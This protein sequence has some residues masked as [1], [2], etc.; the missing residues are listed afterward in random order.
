M[1]LTATVM[2]WL[3]VVG[4]LTLQ[5]CFAK[6]PYK[7]DYTLQKRPLILRSLL[8]IATPYCNCYTCTMPGATVTMPRATRQDIDR[9]AAADWEVSQTIDD[10]PPASFDILA[11]DLRGS[12]GGCFVC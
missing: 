2:G 12:V 3:Q 8:I 7:R 10:Q 11:F 6:E 9:V 4:F 1:E 5:V